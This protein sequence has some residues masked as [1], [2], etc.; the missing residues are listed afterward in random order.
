[1]QETFAQQAETDGSFS[2]PD[3]DPDHVSSE[4]SHNVYSRGD[5]GTFSESEIMTPASEPCPEEEDDQ[6]A[7]RLEA[8]KIELSAEEAEDL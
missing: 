8:E 7:I 6:V 4:H 5:L 3:E 1:M 2:D